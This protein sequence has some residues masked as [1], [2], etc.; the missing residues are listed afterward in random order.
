MIRRR[1]KLGTEGLKPAVQTDAPRERLVS[2]D[3]YQALIEAMPQIAWLA[4]ADGQPDCFNRFWSEYSGLSREQSAGTGWQSAVHPED[5]PV[6]LQN[7]IEA[8]R[9]LSPFESQ[10]RLKRASDATYRWHASQAMPL[11]SP[12]GRFIRWLAI[13]LDVH[14]YK[15]A[16][17]EVQRI[18]ERA[19]VLLEGV[20]DY[21]IF[22][23][24][25]NGCIISWNTGAEGIAG[26]RAD[27]FIGRHV[28]IFYPLEEVQSNRPA[29]ALKAASTRGRFEDEGWRLRKDGSRFWAEEVITPLWQE[30]GILHGF[31]VVM[32]ERS[33]H[34]LT[35]DFRDFLEAVPDALVVSDEQGRILLVNSET[36]RLFGYP[37]ERLLH[38]PVE[39]LIPQQFRTAHATHR[40]DYLANPHTRLMGIGPELLGQRADGSEFPA[41]I[42][43][44]TLRSDQ[45]L[46]V[47]S[48]IRDI[49]ERKR[50]EST[51][52]RTSME[53]ARSNAELEQ[54]AYA[55]SHD[56]QEPLRTI[57]GATQILVRDHS[58]K[59]EPEAR[60]WLGFAAE[61]AKRM[62]GLL[63]ALLY[64]ARLGAQQRP[65]E[66]VDCEYVYRAATANL[67]I[68]IEESRAELTH[69]PL[70]MV[71]G[72]GIQLIQLFQNLLANAIKFRRPE[73]TPQV[74]VWAQQQEKEWRI[75][76]RD[77]G[78]GIDPKN[79]S[80]LFTLFQR[81]HTR[82]EY[83][84]EGIGLAICKKIVERHNGHIGVESTRG[85]G[86]TFY[87]TIPMVDPHSLPA[88]PF[89][90]IPAV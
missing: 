40:K 85:E 60:E 84:G 49:S 59:L 69:S 41:E 10:F 20:K 51:L 79:L 78:V 46:V 90:V 54:F 27:E 42:S 23:L 76:V 8:I 32:R 18:R 73:R 2:E 68:A 4:T 75:S 38:Q 5:L 63:Q 89:K 11:R 66:L 81:L 53:L 21:A 83:D 43:L 77:N 31:A 25:P 17:E 14:N 82:A 86:S 37:R 3:Q 45:G 9:N 24:D 36:E 80:R 16:A 56:M 13:C 61:G 65:F 88:S 55:A 44:T 71:M 28:S 6:Y 12:D 29:E 34:H 62:Q 52:K 33:A 70:P 64:Y 67:K 50:S 22:M 58:E 1:N 26:Y 30:P 87:F 74:H 72:D 19:R 57:I 48:A 15:L 39:M 47:C 7:W 35:T